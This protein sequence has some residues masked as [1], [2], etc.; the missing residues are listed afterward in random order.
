MLLDVNIICIIEQTFKIVINPLD[1]RGCYSSGI[2]KALLIFIIIIIIII[3]ELNIELCLND[4]ERTFY[5]KGD[6]SHAKVYLATLFIIILV[7]CT[8]FDSLF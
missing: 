5:K 6:Q 2:I 8:I 3:I 1:L 4:Q 7:I